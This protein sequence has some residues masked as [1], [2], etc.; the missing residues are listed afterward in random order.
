M[1]NKVKIGWKE[2][3][4]VSK[5]SALNSGEE[6]MGQID[7]DR[8]IITLRDSN[9]KEQNESTLIHEIL[10]GIGNMYG[11]NLDEETVTRLADAIYTIVKDNPSLRFEERTGKER[12]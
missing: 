8:Q 12:D 9:T 7:F 10:H 11:I 5:P 3:D 4:V 6:L 1:L 2:Y